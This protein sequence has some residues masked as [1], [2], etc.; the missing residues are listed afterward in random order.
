MSKQY[1]IFL[2]KVLVLSAILVFAFNIWDNLLNASKVAQNPVTITENNEQFKKISNASNIWKTWVAITTNIWIKFKQRSETPATI[3]RDIFSINEIIQDTQGANQEIIG[4]NMTAVDEYKNV[5][6]TDIKQLIDTS[7]DRARLIDAFIDQLEF[8]YVQWAENIKTLNEQKNVF[9][10]TMNTANTQIET[11][12]I[13]INKDFSESNS[14]ESLDN[15]NE[16]IKLKEQY[17]YA[18]TY[19]IYI[20]HFLEQ[21]SFLSEY[22][23]LLLDTLINN[24]EALIKWAYVVVP[25]SWAGLLDDLDLLYN[26]ETYKKLDN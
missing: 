1:Y 19:I 22:N 9:E 6:K 20:N 18:R 11:L 17:Y 7:Y 14:Q 16:Y 25:D 24:R 23:K 8:R 26:E 5:L 15:I 13:K 10:T 4:A 12:K 21:Y 3:Y 2:L